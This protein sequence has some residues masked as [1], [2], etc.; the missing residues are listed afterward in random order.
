MKTCLILFLSLAGLLNSQI[1]TTSGVVGFTTMTINGNAG[2]GSRL[3][4]GALAMVPNQVYQGTASGA[5]GT[6]VTDSAATWTDDAFNGPNGAHYLEVMSIGG[7]TVASGVGSTYAII[8]CVAATGTITLGSALTA[9]VTAPFVF[10]VRKHWTISSLLGATNS[11]GLQGGTP[12]TAD[13]LLIWNGSRHETYYYQTAGIG[14][15]GW[16]KIGDQSSDAGGTILDPSTAMLVKRGSGTA[17]NVIVSGAVKSRPAFVAITKGYNYVGNPY[18][19][20]MTL[21]SSGI[22]TGNNS[23][24]IAGGT[25]AATS[26]QVLIWNGSDYTTYYYNSSAGGW[27]SATDAGTN[28]DSTS[29][30]GN[31]SLIVHRLN[32]PA[33]TWKIPVHPVQP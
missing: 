33:F 9:G 20:S 12:A 28:A 14:G 21:A 30:T 22:Y 10:C 8:D 18:P 1:S 4:F 25:S 23:T 16:R 26:D 5:A 2:G 13:Q 3:N 11:T 6:T 31:S 27:R 29:I 17:V 24:G 15:T 19:V 32:D 7:S